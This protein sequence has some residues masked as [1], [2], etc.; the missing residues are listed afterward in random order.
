MKVCTDA[1][2][3]G[4]YTA[5]L[6][7]DHVKNILDIGSGTG[8]L[9]L[10]L[11]QFSSANIN[12]IELDENAF[13][14]TSHNFRLSVWKE[15]LA[16]IQN[17]IRQFQSANLFDLIICNPPFYENDL[18]S[19]N[20]FKNSAMHST[21]LTLEELLIAINNLLSSHGIASVMI[22][23]HRRSYFQ[24]LVTENKLHIIRE[25]TISQ[26]TK[27]TNF[28]SVCILSKVPQILVQQ[29][30]IIKDNENY[31]A[32]FIELMKPYYLNL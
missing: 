5:T 8:L 26:T 27:H 13:L 4:A 7:N 28:R 30:L 17:D 3:Q 1:C 12:A 2:I 19:P 20:E 24:K 6:L 9:S 11:A 10:M 21:T 32:D 14:Q 29:N 15:N 25:L 22:P 16:V 18:V 31:T 23:Y